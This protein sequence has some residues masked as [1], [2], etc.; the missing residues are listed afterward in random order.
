M[1]NTAKTIHRPN[2]RMTDREMMMVDIKNWTRELT[3]VNHEKL[4]DGYVKE[5]WQ[6]L[7]NAT[8]VT[9]FQTS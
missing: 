1:T 2:V 3:E 7:N 4:D 9:R 5:L 6:H 8:Q